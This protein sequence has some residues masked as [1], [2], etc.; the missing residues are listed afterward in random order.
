MARGKFLTVEG[1]EGVGKS[2]NIA[3]IQSFLEERGIDLVVTREPG[4]TPLAEEL[5]EMLLAKREETFNATAELLIIFAARAQHLQTI[6]LPALAQGRWVLSDRFTDATFAYQGCGRGLNIEHITLLENLVQGELRPDC[7]FLLDIDV[8]VGLQRAQQRAELDRFE[9]EK[10]EFFENVRQGYLA[11]VA[12][13]PRRYQ[14]IN[15]GQ[16]LASVQKDL[17][18]A[19]TELVNV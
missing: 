12:E 13:N 2:T 3:F 11:R 7:T 5:R 9:C 15:A 4:G 1:T 17:Y 19:L 16:D 6:I 14:K 10:I 18:K 8:K